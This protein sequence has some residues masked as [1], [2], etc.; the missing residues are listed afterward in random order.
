MT[1]GDPDQTLSGDTIMDR[2]VEYMGDKALQLSLS[3][4]NDWVKQAAAREI[5]RREQAEAP[6]SAG[7][8]NNITPY[9]QPIGPL[10]GLEV[11]PLDNMVLPSLD[12][13]QVG[14]FSSPVQPILQDNSGNDILSPDKQSIEARILANLQNGMISDGTA[15]S[16]L[17]AAGLNQIVDMTPSAGNPQT[18]DIGLTDD[19][20]L[21]GKSNPSK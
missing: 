7:V 10:A 20:I 21:S 5:A 19:H 11:V 12:R 14:G 1:P 15:N 16:Q 17:R 3:A 9:S 8:A 18:N 6:N 2:P 4:G 13:T